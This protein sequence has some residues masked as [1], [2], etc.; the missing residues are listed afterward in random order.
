M[1]DTHPDV[2]SAIHNRLARDQEVRQARSGY[3]PTVDFEAGAGRN[4]VDKP[5]DSDLDPRLLRLG[6]RQN[7]FAGLSTKNEIERQKARVESQA[8]LIRS[9]ADNMALRVADVY[10]DVLK[11]QAINDLAQ[12]NLLLHQ[13]I[14]DQV[15]LR[16]AS[17]VDSRADMDQIRSRLSL[18][19]AGVVVSEQNLL[20]AQ[21]AYNAVVGNLP[22][23]LQRP[24]DMS[25][26]LP[27]TMA[28]AEELA[29]ASHPQLKS[30]QA[31][32]QAR[33]AQEEVAKSPFMPVVDFEADQVFEEDTSYNSNYDGYEREDLRLFLR[34]RYNLFNG[35]KDEARKTETM[36]LVNE[37]QEIRNH[38][39][40]Q[41]VES[42]R[43][44]WRAH[45][46]AQKQINYLAQ[47]LEFAANTADAYTLQWNIGQRTLLDVLDAE[48]ER[49]D[50]ARQLVTAEYDG[51]YA[52]CRILNSTGQLIPALQMQWPT[53]STTADGNNAA[54]MPAAS[55]KS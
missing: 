49:I 33:R 36:H 41:V 7:I 10:L 32:L 42:T 5:F 31:D 27:P 50:S 55:K 40:R 4:Y 37:A 29:L 44:S 2:R 6:L 43:L 13:R 46:A 12:E 54:V 1:I 47:R 15:Q 24:A 23:K 30:A 34:L 11:Y 14:A 25:K 22:E 20:D 16:S 18:A 3:F 51:L 9:T 19:H 48:A 53:E 17:G 35:W 39:H 38:T 8:Y 28:K 26:L 45:E 21:T 52:Q